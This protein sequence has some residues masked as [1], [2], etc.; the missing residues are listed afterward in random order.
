[1]TRSR[2]GPVYALIPGHLDKGQY[3][4]ARNARETADSQTALADYGFALDVGSC[5]LYD[6]RIGAGVYPYQWCWV[7]NAR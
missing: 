4:A 5:K 2:S 1:M 3:D 6:A 7:A